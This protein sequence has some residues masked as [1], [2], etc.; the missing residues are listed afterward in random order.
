[1]GN[2]PARP[3]CRAALAQ[4]RRFLTALAETGN[5]RLAARDLGLNRS[6][7]TKRRPAPVPDVAR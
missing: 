3:L 1:M 4:N 7:L 2:V 6:A 5:A